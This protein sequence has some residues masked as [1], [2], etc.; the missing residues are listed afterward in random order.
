MA[1]S[2]AAGARIPLKP[3]FSMSQRVNKT[4]K[5]GIE[6][7]KKLIGILQLWREKR[8]KERKRMMLAGHAVPKEMA[9]AL[10]RAYQAGELCGDVSP[11]RVV[12][13]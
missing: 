10:E 12:K 8:E 7:S 11:L 3:A 9:E 6:G 1:A 5:A 4:F 13:G 2:A